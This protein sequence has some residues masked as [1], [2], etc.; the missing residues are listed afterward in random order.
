MCL[1]C[2]LL[3]IPFLFLSLDLRLLDSIYK[4]LHIRRWAEKFIWWRHIYRWWLFLWQHGPEN[5]KTIL[6]WEITLKY[7]YLFR[8]LGNISA[9]S[10]NLRL[11]NSPSDSLRNLRFF[12]FL[13]K[14]HFA[15]TKAKKE[16]KK[17]HF[18]FWIV[19]L[20]YSYN[21]MK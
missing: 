2:G 10:V 13:I 21:K 3:I 17:K 1:V 11:R 19:N 16:N 9:I 7:K 5:V 12:I 8:I 20:S 6:I 18:L 14:D 15:P 4:S